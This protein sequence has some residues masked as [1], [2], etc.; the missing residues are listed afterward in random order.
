MAAQ[1][2]RRAVLR[3]LWLAGAD[4]DAASVRDAAARRGLAD[5]TPA[6][7]AARRASAAARRG[8]LWE[9]HAALLGVD[10]ALLGEVD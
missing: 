9:K 6:E 2:G 1:H 3:V 8:G 5:A 4:C 7:A 10:A